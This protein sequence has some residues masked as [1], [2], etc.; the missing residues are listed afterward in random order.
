[1]EASLEGLVVAGID[2]PISM[3]P[4]VAQLFFKKQL[5]GGSIISERVI[6]TAAHCLFGDD[7]QVVL[8]NEV[9]VYLG[10]DWLREGA[11]YNICKLVPHENYSGRNE[12]SF[13]YYDL[14]LVS[15]QEKIKF[16]RSVK[17]MK[18]ANTESFRNEKFGFTIAGFG[19][20]SSS[21]PSGPSIKLKATRMYYVST[22][23]CNESQSFRNVMNVP[24][25]MFCMIGKGWASDCYG[26]SGSG[27]IWK[28]SLVGVVALGRDIF[29]GSDMLPSMYTD[30]VYFRKWVTEKVIELE[31]LPVE[32][33]G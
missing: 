22:K 5:C 12:I 6:L 17:M 9:M 1:M 15:L 4:H 21:F 14:G 10:S 2:V 27:I 29:C 23:K 26:D 28:R 25:H 20:V 16:G 18:I 24:D 31:S 13:Y 8:P 3:Y 32:Q 33:C 11:N 19:A 7:G 30:I